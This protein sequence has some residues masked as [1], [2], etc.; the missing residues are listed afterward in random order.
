M[1]LDN[2]K[3]IDGY[4]GEY[5]INIDGVIFSHNYWNKGIKHPMKNSMNSKGYYRVGLSKGGVVR[6]FKV[7]RLVM[8]TF[9]E[10]DEDRPNINHI[11]GDKSNNS[12]DNLEWCTQYEN[13]HHAWE[14]GLSKSRH[15]GKG[16]KR[17]LQIL[18]GEVISKYIGVM[19]AS[20]KSGVDASSISRVCKGNQILAGGY[21][22]KYEQE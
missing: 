4:E 21:K 10:I 2:E 9:S 17:V 16:R 1:I 8:E 3:W 14:N 22:W 15:T 13:I 18:D 5:S 6:D 11:D 20:R 12:L 19:D 7:H